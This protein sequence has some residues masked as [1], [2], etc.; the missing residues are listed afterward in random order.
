MDHQDS[1][2]ASRRRSSRIRAVGVASIP[3]QQASLEND[4]SSSSSAAPPRKRNAAART[5]KSKAKRSHFQ[6]VTNTVAA[7]QKRNSSSSSSEA[8]FHESP[9]KKSRRTAS[10][11][12]AALARKT[13]TP[14]APS[15]KN[16]STAVRSQIGNIATELLKSASRKASDASSSAIA[17]PHGVV[18]LYPAASKSRPCVCDDNHCSSQSQSHCFL[19]HYG[20]DYFQS[21]KDWET[22]YFPTNSAD[23]DSLS[24]DDTRSFGGASSA[25]SSSHRSRGT[26]PNRVNYV[27][28]SVAEEESLMGSS[29]SSSTTLL[30]HQPHLTEKMRGVLID[31]LIELSEEYK[32]SARTLHLTAVLLNRSLEGSDN[33]IVDHDENKGDD[34][35]SSMMSATKGRRLVMDR[36][37][38]QCLGWY[39]PN[40]VLLLLYFLIRLFHSH[41]FF[42]SLEL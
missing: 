8:A 2:E 3:A 25:A 10:T 31:W 1:N 39:V 16:L 37:M 19:N 17:L 21:L 4:S 14:V 34:E 7:S 9:L 38:F 13:V 28:G 22:L 23:V 27:I 42:F 20:K 24:S 32:L 33:G 6:D 41:S 30:E 26:P 15:N 12:D 18:N 40:C 5:K 36:D 11:L 35:S 29:S